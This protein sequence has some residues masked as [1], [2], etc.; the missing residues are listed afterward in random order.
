LPQRPLLARSCASRFLPCF[1]LLSLRAVLI[2]ENHL[3]EAA[4]SPAETLPT[5]TRTSGTR[6]G[7]ALRLDAVLA[8]L[9]TRRRAA[10]TRKLPAA[11]PAPAAPLS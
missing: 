1:C 7:A 2:I 8:I 3:L 4:A 11:Q 10:T 9:R 5:G 6:R